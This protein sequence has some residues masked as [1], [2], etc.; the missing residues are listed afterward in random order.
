MLDVIAQL[1]PH[2]STLAPDAT[3]QMA[4]LAHQAGNDELAYEILPEGPDGVGN[5]LWIEE[6]LELATHLEDN[7]RIARFDTRLAELFPCSERL[8][9]NR[10]RRLLMNS[11]KAKSGES[12]LFTTAGLKDHHLTLQGWL[13]VDEPEYRTVIEEARAWGP[14]WLELAV[15]CCAIH[16]QSVGKPRA[17]ADL[18]SPVTSSEL[19]G[20][21][22]TQVLLWSIKSMMLKELVPEDERDCYQHLFQAAFRFLAYHPE[23]RSVRAGLTTLLSV[24]SCGDMGIP[25]LAL[26]MLDLAQQGVSLALPNTDADEEHSSEIDDAIEASMKNGLIWLGN[27]GGE[28]RPY[29]HEALGTSCMRHLPSCHT[30]TRRRHSAVEAPGQPIRY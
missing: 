10:D 27:L 25:L 3:I 13:A 4:R 29:V 23:D 17:A 15:V 12:H 18:A 1:L 9:E 11:R 20:R 21:Q 30:G 14:D 16:A 19:Y 6:G 24:E 7:E 8:R 26:A 5:R 2:L 22:A 28:R